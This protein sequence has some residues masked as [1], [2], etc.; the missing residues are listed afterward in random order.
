MAHDSPDSFIANMSKAKRQRRIFID[1]LRN[2]LTSTATS[3]FSV[4][5]RPSAAVAFAAGYEAACD[6]LAPD[7]APKG[8]A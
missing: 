1:Y 5:A 4:R 7:E 3:A 6:L 2:D 8:H